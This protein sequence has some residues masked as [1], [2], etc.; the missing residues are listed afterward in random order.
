MKNVVPPTTIDGVVSTT[1]LDV[2]VDKPAEELIV[3]GAPTSTS[4]PS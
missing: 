3:P 1:G 2:I 4:E